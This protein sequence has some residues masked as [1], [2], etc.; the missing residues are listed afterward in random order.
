MALPTTG[1]KVYSLAQVVCKVGP[2]RLSEWG[3]DGTITID[4]QSDEV[5]SALSG[6]GLAH[7]SDLNDRRLRVT[8]DLMIKSYAR[9]ALDAL[10]VAQRAARRPPQGATPIIP[11]LP[12]YFWNPSTGE[13]ITSPYS[14]FI[15]VPGPTAAKTEGT[16][17]YVIELP[18]GRD[19][20]FN[21]PQEAPIP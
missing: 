21:I 3:P 10:V 13:K 9:E 15:Q 7:Y 20:Q 8:V 12:F 1:A 18:Y 5:E 17:Q 4:P 19:G 14:V 16:R 6:D 11:P 2:V